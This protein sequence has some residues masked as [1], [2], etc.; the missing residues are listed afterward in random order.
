M[1]HNKRIKMHILFQVLVK[2][3]SWFGGP[4][5]DVLWIDHTLKFQNLIGVP[6]L[7]KLTLNAGKSVKNGNSLHK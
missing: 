2:V 7:V 3:K 5:T 6:M 4:K 1:Y